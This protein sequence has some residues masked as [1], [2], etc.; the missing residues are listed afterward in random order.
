MPFLGNTGTVMRVTRRTL[1]LAAAAALA[2]LALPAAALAW[3][4]VYPT[5]DQYGST[6]T[7][8]VSDSYP[9]DQA[10]PQTWATYLGT[11]VHGP[12]LARLTLDLAPIGE[13]TAICGA[14]ALACY[15]PS[16]QTIE[17]T[18]EDQL[19]SPPAQEIV[20]HEYGHHIANNRSDAPWSAESYGTKRWA[21]YMQICKRTKDGTLAPGDEGTSYSLNPGEAFA[22][23][24][25][26]LNLTRAGATTIDWE[27]V[28]PSFY[29]DATALSL[30]SAD[31][32]APWVGATVR[33]VR[34][35]FGYGVTRTIGVTTALDGSFVA[36][37]HAAAKSR[38]SLA[39]YSGSTLLAHGTTVQYQI[40]GQRALTLKVERQSGAGAFT[41]D[42]SK[43]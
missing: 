35:S 25:R 8:Q 14:G 21:S 13:V 39:L 37:L 41:V 40:C 24:Y 34:G 3:G 29:P 42:I 6:I 12:E 10:L 1:G 27:I 9:V 32:T 22:E 5:G 15:D 18:P 36:R 28:D 16:A 17:A 7:I 19:D 26:V 4:G 38:M 23:A 33:H 11:L 31:V 20:T 30:L 43:P 2:C